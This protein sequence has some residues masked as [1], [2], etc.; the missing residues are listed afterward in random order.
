[1]SATKERQQT[2]RRHITLCIA[3]EDYSQTRKTL[4]AT[5][6]KNYNHMLQHFL[7]D[8]LNKPLIDLTKEMIE[9]VARTRNWNFSIP[10]RTF[11]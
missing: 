11:Y 5:T 7:S 2:K 9:K 6:L 8:W 1:M 4:K 3:Y 10:S